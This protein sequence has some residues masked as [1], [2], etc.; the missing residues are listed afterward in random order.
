MQIIG[1]SGRKK[2][3][4]DTVCSIIQEIWGP[5]AK[6]FAFA[7]ALK[8]EL[9]HATGVPISQ[10]EQDKDRFRL[11]LQWWGTEFRR[12]QDEKYWVSKLEHAIINAGMDGGCDIA[13]ITDCRFRNEADSVKR[14]G[15]IV[16]RIDRPSCCFNDAHA[17]ETSMDG[18]DFDWI[19]PNA[20][21]LLELEMNVDTMMQHLFNG[22]PIAVASNAAKAMPDRG[23]ELAGQ[24]AL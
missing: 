18:Y 4:K 12:S 21:S 8:Y 2:S 11:G 3:G 9:S 14:M 17:S 23:A 20:G 16:C 13:I 1:L 19:I 6:R 24:L 22:G 15:G 10:I 5:K 7:D